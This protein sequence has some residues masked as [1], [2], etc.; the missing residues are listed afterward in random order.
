MDDVL[1]YAAI[2]SDL[3][4]WGEYVDPEATMTEAE[5][6]AM[7]VEEKIAV[8]IECFGEERL[9]PC[10]EAVA[11]YTE[12]VLCCQVCFEEVSHEEL[13]AARPGILGA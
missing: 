9:T 8:Q 5:F 2:A 11:Q 1:T 13:V 6:E 7:S 12:G 10:C 3:N 4:L